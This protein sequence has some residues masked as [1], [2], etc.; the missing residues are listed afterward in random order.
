MIW[1][2]HLSLELGQTWGFK[3][4]QERSLINLALVFAFSLHMRHKTFLGLE[5]Y[6]FLSSNFKIWLSERQF[7]ESYRFTDLNQSF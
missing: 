6:H 7:L 4:R 2:V 3:G 1:S 5:K